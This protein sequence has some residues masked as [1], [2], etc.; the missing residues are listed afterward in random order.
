MARPFEQV[1]QLLGQDVLGPVVGPAEL[2]EQPYYGDVDA[3]CGRIGLFGQGRVI[4]LERQLPC[5]GRRETGARANQPEE[6]FD[7]ILIP[8]PGQQL[9]G[10]FR[11]AVHLDQTGVVTEIGHIVRCFGHE[12]VV[13]MQEVGHSRGWRTPFQAAGVAAIQPIGR[14]RVSP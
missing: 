11:V 7:G 6:L 12:R 5:L 4:A 9:L 1:S 13:I 8:G 10:N 3:A 2:E 14:I